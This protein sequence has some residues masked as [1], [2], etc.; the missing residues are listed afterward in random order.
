MSGKQTTEGYAFYCSCSRLVD[1]R[2]VSSTFCIGCGLFYHRWHDK[3]ETIQNYVPPPSR[4]T[5]LCDECA[6]PVQGELFA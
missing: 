4:E 6:Q 3:S 2:K 5:C 1:L